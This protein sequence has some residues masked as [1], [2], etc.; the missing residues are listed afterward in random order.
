CAIVRAR[1][2]ASGQTRATP[3]PP[4]R[5]SDPDPARVRDRPPAQWRGGGEDPQGPP[6]CHANNQPTRGLPPR[7]PP[8]R[9]RRV[10]CPR[11][12][13][14]GSPTPLT[15][16]AVAQSQCSSARVVAARSALQFL[17][18]RAPTPEAEGGCV[19]HRELLLRSQVTPLAT[20]RA[21]RARSQ[22]RKRA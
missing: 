15:T 3:K 17:R 2:A 4:I 9:D 20:R 8:A 10:R 16:L 11:G 7:R 21:A 1:P 5:R 6:V 18:P 14:C 22:T 13:L 19:H 12:R